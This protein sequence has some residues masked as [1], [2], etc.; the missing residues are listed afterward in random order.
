[1]RRP[2]RQEWSTVSRII[3]FDGPKVV[4]VLCKGTPVCEALD[5]LRP[6]NAAEALVHQ[7]LAGQKRFVFGS[8]QQ[9]F[10]EIDR[11][12]PTVPEAEGEEEEED[13]GSEGGNPIPPH[14]APR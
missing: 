12:L 9:G 4:W 6:V 1:M 11:K 13:S 7:F 2:E 14:H 5:R 10:I 8:G 3:G